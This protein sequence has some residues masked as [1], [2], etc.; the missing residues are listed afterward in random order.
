MKHPFAKDFAFK[1]DPRL[2]FVNQYCELVG[3]KAFA[4]W[5]FNL[6][7]FL[8]VLPFAVQKEI[9]LM[10]TKSFLQTPNPL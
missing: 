5:T 10:G 6:F 9:Y 3:F 4:V 2:L 7:L 8:S 1:R